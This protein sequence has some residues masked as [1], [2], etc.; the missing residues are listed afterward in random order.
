MQKYYKDIPSSLWSLHVVSISQ[1]KTGKSRSSRHVAEPRIRHQYQPLEEIWSDISIYVPSTPRK[2]VT[3]DLLSSWAQTRS[4]V[5]AQTLSLA[6]TRSKTETRLKHINIKLQNICGQVKFLVSLYTQMQMHRLPC[7]QLWF[8][9][10]I[11][12]DHVLCV[13]CTQ[14][15]CAHVR[16]PVLCSNTPLPTVLRRGGVLGHRTVY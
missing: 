1:R 11:R 2:C 8:A 14:C 3:A 15:A 10:F 4:A 12:N 7:L 5:A 9:W 16:P 13:L 6:R